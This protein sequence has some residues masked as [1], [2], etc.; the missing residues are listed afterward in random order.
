[1]RSLLWPSLLSEYPHPFPLEWILT[2]S[3]VKAES[4]T[5]VEGNAQVE[6]P[7]VDNLKPGEK[8]FIMSFDHDDGQWKETGTAVV[9]PDGKKLV[10]GGLRV[11]T[12]GWKFPGKPNRRRLFPPR[13][14]R[15]DEDDDDCPSGGD[16]EGNGDTDAE[17][18]RLRIVKTD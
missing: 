4:A 17:M 1:M 8:T 5:V 6:F 11:N 12:L 2:T 9:S 3:T 18:E 10:T 7:N 15:P 13:R 16:S 14:R